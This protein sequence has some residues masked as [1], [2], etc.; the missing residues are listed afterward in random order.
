MIIIGG[1]FIAAAFAVW[2]KDYIENFIAAGIIGCTILTYIF[3][4]LGVIQ[5]GVYVTVAASIAA[6]IFTGWTIARNTDRT[7]YILTYG[8]LVF[9][10]L[11]VA[12]IVLNKNVD[13]AGSPDAMYWV[14]IAKG[15]YWFDSY[16]RGLVIDTH[17][18]FI[19]IWAYLA[20]KTWTGWSD[21]LL[22]ASNNVLKVSLLLPFLSLINDKGSDDAFYKRLCLTGIIVFLPNQS[23]TNEY[24]IFSS[25]MLMGLFFL[26]GLIMFL[27]AISESCRRYFLIS[28][29]SF[30]GAVQTKRIAIAILALFLI[31]I[32]YILIQKK[33]YLVGV[34]YL[35][36]PIAVYL[37]ARHDIYAVA[38]LGAM[39]ASVILFLLMRIKSKIK[40]IVLGVAMV[41]IFV[42]IG[43]A[44]VE[45]PQK[46][47]VINAGA[48][49]QSYLEMLF[50]SS[51][52]FYVVGESV[53]LPVAV[54]LIISL[55]SFVVFDR[56]KIFRNVTAEEMLIYCGSFA[57]IFAY[58]ALM[59]YL[60]V[61]QIAAASGE[62][63]ESSLLGISRY[64][65]IIPGIIFGLIIYFVLTKTDNFRYATIC[66][67]IIMLLS[68]VTGII[69][70][71]MIRRE[72]VTFEEFDKA[73]LEITEN[74]RI[75]YINMSMNNSFQ[76]FYFTY[77][78]I[79]SGVIDELSW[80]YRNANNGVYLGIE[81][82]RAQL[83]SYDYLYIDNTDEKF[84]ELY[85]DLFVD[86]TN[87]GTDDTVYQ[88]NKENGTLVRR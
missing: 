88:I 49:V 17:P 67:L 10:V 23:T 80:T 9:V 78:P 76:S 31:W 46:Y 51:N 20:M 4:V 21:T 64:M 22:V 39:M 81:E 65:K 6:L 37:I 45:M 70:H 86:K 41:F 74:T 5:V 43:Y 48:I 32:F 58:L 56:L 16:Q 24:S 77:F 8:A 57:T 55:L 40:Y 11:S 71:V 59:F 50:R 1:F 60:Y 75:A 30:A 53:R 54:F 13:A 79:E 29:M 85:R 62:M 3:A 72:K 63:F 42:V 83:M 44:L 66:M 15:I 52:E 26:L 27:R 7:R 69:D 47:G 2:Q 61:T 34:L 82:L 14:R 36:V 73:D 33:E 68:N 18:Q 28:I 38:P 25:D 87:I 35:V 12:L 19:S 84:V